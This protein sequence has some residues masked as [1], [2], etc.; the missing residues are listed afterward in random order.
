MFNIE[1]H[2]DN[3]K[4]RVY[5]HTLRHTFASYLEIKQV[6]LFEMQK[7]MNYRDINMILRYMKLVEA[8]KVSA[9]KGIY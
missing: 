1:L 8:N 4:N 5:N 6:L 9:V 2:K 7:L 3:A